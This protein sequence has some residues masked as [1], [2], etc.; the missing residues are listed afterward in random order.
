MI[1]LARYVG[2]RKGA[3]TFGDATY[4]KLFGFSRRCL[5]LHVEVKRCDQR[6]DL[7]K[8]LSLHRRD[9]HPVVE[10]DDGVRCALLRLGPS[11]E[12]M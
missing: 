5:G 12:D 11:A 6:C 7:D 4:M 9:V 3:A 8:Q 10:V 1:L 2:S